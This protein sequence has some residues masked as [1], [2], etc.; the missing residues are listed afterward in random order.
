MSINPRFTSQHLLIFTCV[1][2]TLFSLSLIHPANQT[3]EKYQTSTYGKQYRHVERVWKMAMSD[4]KKPFSEV[5]DHWLFHKINPGGFKFIAEM[6]AR[7]G[8]SS[9]IPLQIVLVLLV[10]LGIIAQFK[11]LSAFFKNNIFPVIGCLIILG[12]HFL[13][14]FGSTI[15]QHAYNFSFFNFCMFFI[16]KYAQTKN[17]KYY[18][19]TWF[20]YLFLC[21][22]YYMFWVSTFIMMVGIQYF[23]GVKIIS[24]QNF[25]LGLA[26]VLTIAFLIWN[27]SLVHGGFDK[28]MTRFNK[29][30]KARAAGVVAKGMNKKPMVAKDY[31]KYP[32]TVSSRIERYFYIPGI[33]F[34]FLAWIL[35]RLKIANNSTLNYR[36]FYFVVPA[37]LSWY[38]LMWQ[39]TDVHQV[40]GRYS[41]FLWMIFF[42]YFFTEMFEWIKAKGQKNEGSQLKLF[43]KYNWIFV[44]IYGGYGFLY[45]NVSNLIGNLVRVFNL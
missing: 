42:G 18:A 27:I 11:W 20:C 34:L 15:H 40:A 22:N 5:K 28:A 25:V 6:F 10:N 4:A 13:T 35:R 17:L 26:P 14:F 7:A 3:Y 41:Y 1:F 45:F 19:L 21:Q 29:V 24:L 44:L 12:T 38:M 31:V 37:G 39:H 43:L 33:V 23:H 32:L 30:A 8:F 16:L 2:F 36:F 9:P